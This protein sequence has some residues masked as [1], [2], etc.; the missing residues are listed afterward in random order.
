MKRR[1][2]RLNQICHIVAGVFNL[3]YVYTPLRE[4]SFAIT[5][6]QF[7]TMPAL[8]LTGIALLRMPKFHKSAPC[9][10]CSPIPMQESVK[11]A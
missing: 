7:V 9:P 11:S 10:T 5:I 4:W 8:L 6:V 1:S 3:A 2:F